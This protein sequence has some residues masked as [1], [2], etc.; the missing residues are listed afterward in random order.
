MPGD[1]DEV[2]ALGLRFQA[3]AREITAAAQRLRTMCTDAYWDSG[4]GEAFR[5]RSVQTAGK[6]SAAFDRYAAAA[7]AL[8]TSPMDAAPSTGSRPNYAGALDQA[9]AISLRALL[10][11]QDAATT[12]RTTLSQLSAEYGPYL[13]PGALVPGADG[14][15]PPALALVPAGAAGAATGTNIVALVSRYNAAADAITAARNLI[16]QAVAL[17]DKAAGDAAGLITSVIGSD[18]L[19]DSFW[20][21]VTN[22]ID[23]H[24]GV[25]EKISEVAGWVATVAGTL[26]LVVGWIPIVGQALAAVLG[27]VALAAS[28]VALLSDALLKIGGEGSWADLA[29]DT[30]AVASFGLGRAAV[31]AVRDSALLARG[32]GRI[33][34]VN[35]VLDESMTSDVYLRGGEEALDDALSAAWKS[36]AKGFDDL[37][38]EELKTARQHAPGSWPKWG[39]I[40]RGFQPASILKDGFKDIGDLK[41]SNWEELGEK[42]TWEGA[43]VFLGDPEI[44]EA[45]EGVGK[46]GDLSKLDSVRG[47]AA[48]VSSNHNAWRLVTAPAVIAD[49]AN[50]VLTQGGWKDG[51]LHD[52]GLGWAAEAPG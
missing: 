33:E 2:A 40:L 12:Q 3:T 14:H 50:H 25:L 11:A 30:I 22:F 46:L 34:S 4:A 51:L 19:S 32:A 24:A 29:L 13:A 38:D 6:L 9:Q 10:P 47:F 16:A 41:L 45:L 15:L 44:R 26:A 8:G 36:D 28:V 18:G 35:R 17:R 23:V 43:R 7:A 49:S 1:P 52:T 21:H 5:Q 20:D 31:G 39:D 37:G 42:K 27:T 48:N